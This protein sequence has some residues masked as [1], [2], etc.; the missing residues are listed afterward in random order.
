MANAGKLILKYALL[1]AVFCG[2]A[3]LLLPLVHDLTAPRIAA[4]QQKLEDDSLHL[5]FPEGKE[6][7]PK[8]NYY[9]AFDENGRLI[10]YVLKIRS[11]GYSSEIEMLVGLK[12]ARDLQITGVKVL[13]QMETPGLGS[14]VE[15][16]T[17]LSNLTGRTRRTLRLRK[18]GG[19]IDAITGATI[20]SRAVVDGLRRNIET[21]VA[22]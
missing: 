14:K 3:G 1:L 21:F 16:S 2:M 7:I 12:K 8:D 15:N 9:E 5:V 22:I 17:F 18:D 10:G 19:D 20:T 6:I 4:Y 13:S 11:Q